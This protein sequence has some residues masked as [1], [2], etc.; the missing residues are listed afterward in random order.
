MRVEI[1][2]GDGFA[3]LPPTSA[4]TAEIGAASEG[5]GHLVG[6]GMT[7]GPSISP[8]ARQVGYGAAFSGD[9]LTHTT[10]EVRGTTYTVDTIQLTPVTLMDNTMGTNISIIV[11]PAIADTADF[12]NVVLVVDGQEQSLANPDHASPF[13]RGPPMLPPGCMPP[14][15]TYPCTSRW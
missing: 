13:V 2:D 4:A 5:K 6:G 15:T 3:E 12:A 7:A 9:A 14:A 11:T 8:G 1:T 10:F